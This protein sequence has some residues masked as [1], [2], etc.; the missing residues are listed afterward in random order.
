MALRNNGESTSKDGVKYHFP[1]LDRKL[2]SAALVIIDRTEDLYTP[3]SC[4]GSHPLAHRILNTLK[5]YQYS[6]TVEEWNRGARNSYD[7]SVKQLSHVSAAESIA[8]T[9][10]IL[11]TSKKFPLLSPMSGVLNAT[12]PIS[13]SMRYNC[14][15]DLFFQRASKSEY[16]RKLLSRDGFSIDD[17]MSDRTLLEVLTGSEDAGRNSLVRNLKVRIAAEKGEPPPPKKRGLGAEV[18]AFVQA[19]AVSPGES[20]GDGQRRKGSSSPPAYFPRTCIQSQ[21]MLGLA[22]AVVESMQRSSSK[23][24]HSLCSWQCC[25]DTR[26]T[27]EMD[28]QQRIQSGS[29][30]LDVCL[31]LLQSQLSAKI[32]SQ[33]KDAPGRG[34]EKEKAVDSNVVDLIYTLT[35]IIR[36]D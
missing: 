19:L 20:D 35:Q 2:S 6:E 3:L 12:F 31:S 24:F 25:Y 18:L 17:H 26:A 23:Q 1:P 21:G 30:D 27:R 4:S 13:P 7:I 8:S 28:M 15:Q 9:R 10:N 32:V 33:Q 22:L 5:C 36:L 34:A 16:L 29:C 11:T 14:E